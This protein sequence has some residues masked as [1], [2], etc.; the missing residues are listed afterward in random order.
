MTTQVFYDELRNCFLDIRNS[1][2]AK[3]F[4]MRQTL[5]DFFNYIIGNTEAEEKLN[6]AN[7]QS[8]WYESTSNYRLNREITYIRQEMNKVVHGQR[9]NISDETLRAFYEYCVRLV[10][11]IT[12]DM[13]DASTLAAYGHIDETYLSSLNTLQKDAVLASERIVYVNA[14]PGTG[15]T[16]LLVYKILDLLIKE[17][18]KAKIVS[19]SYTRSSASSLSA[20][21]AEEGSKF[22]VVRFNSPYSGTIHSYSLNSLKAFYKSKGLL[23]DYIIA[24]ESE[25][26][27]LADDIY[28]STDCIYQREVILDGLCRPDSIQDERLRQILEDTKKIYKRISVG[29]ILHLYLKTLQE[30]D[31]FIEW[32]ANNVN[33]ILV[34][35]AQ[36]L[37]CINYQIFDT[38]IE[39][40]PNLKLFLVGDP[41]QNIFGFLGGSYKHLDAFLSKH[42]TISSIKQL[43]NTYRCPKCIVDFTNS[44]AFEDCAN[45]QITSLQEKAG[46]I[47]VYEYD[48]EYQEANEIVRYILNVRE[49]GSVAILTPRLKQISKVVDRLNETGIPFVVYGGAHSVKPHIM[50]FVYLNRIAETNARS[51]GP[52]NAL[53]EKFNLPK[54]RNVFDF[55]NTDIGIEV[56][57]LYKN[58][59]HR[60]ISY[61]E[62]CRNFV[63]ICRRYFSGDDIDKDYKQLY[64]SVIKNADS[65][66]SFGKIFKSYKGVFMALEVE[67]KSTGNNGKPITIST[68]HSAKGLEWDY[69]IL[70]CMCDSFFPGTNVS[71]EVDY[72]AKNESLNSNLKLMYVAVTRTKGDLLITYP[73]YIRDS[74]KHTRPSRFLKNILL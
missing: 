70:P 44:L 71:D 50:A 40:I 2:D 29:E 61:L 47:E 37:S 73:G 25:I 13:P 57:R 5:E 32:V 54:H 4:V 14:G 22:N 23:F 62:M 33:Y 53:C 46:R 19:M 24:D 64:E 6:F 45:V 30:N 68:M 16:R 48:D 7:A 10:N 39:K 34:D 52:M 17:K 58:Y 42:Q 3:V 36:D 28:Y 67:Y 1:N 59:I 60:N 51:L 72:E 26:E 55:L 15:K 20:K 31:E 38:L 11:L 56:S 43:N 69:V 12:G 27:D 18:D 41:R 65:P 8:V 49:K 63:K 74:Q 66:S 9:K 21:I 35:E